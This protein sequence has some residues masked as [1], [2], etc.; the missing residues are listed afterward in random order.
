MYSV[1]QI[2]PLPLKVTKMEIIIIKPDYVDER[3][4]EQPCGWRHDPE[5]DCLLCF[6]ERMEHEEAMREY[7]EE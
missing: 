4:P 2:R 5:I 1:V 7:D 3:F 6:M